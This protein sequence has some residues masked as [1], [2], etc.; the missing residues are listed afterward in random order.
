SV[1]RIRE[2][3]GAV[4]AVRSRAGGPRDRRGRRPAADAGRGRTLGRRR[5]HGRRGRSRPARAVPDD[6]CARARRYR[7][8][9]LERPRRR[10]SGVP[11][12]R[13]ARARVARAA[14]RGARV[15]H[16]GPAR[17]GAYWD[18][19]IKNAQIRGLA[20][21]PVF[22]RKQHTDVSY[23]A[24]AKALLHEH[25]RLDPQFATHNAHTVAWILEMGA[26]RQY[27]FQ[28]LHGM[29]EELYA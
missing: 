21:Y 28:R 19:E 15:P 18:S 29:G 11:E 6:L 3:L 23:L 10:R 27:E 7:I 26:G 8:A 5:P 17:Q 16:P 1:E 12:A 13:A 22:T 2:T 14:G 20:G 4:A 24:C 25:T 9:R